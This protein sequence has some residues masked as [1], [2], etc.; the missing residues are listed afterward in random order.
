MGKKKDEPVL[1]SG[2]AYEAF[3]IGLGMTHAAI[4]KK[5]GKNERTSRRWSDVGVK[6]RSN[7]VLLSTIGIR[8]AGLD[9][10]RRKKPI[11]EGAPGFLRAKKR[12]R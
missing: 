5:L 9:A 2:D 11:G 8:P 6:T 1:M 12:T 4:A 10:V 3:R 7:M